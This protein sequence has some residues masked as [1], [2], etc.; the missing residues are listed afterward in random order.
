MSSFE[1]EAAL[2]QLDQNFERALIESAHAD[3]LP[4]AA[5]DA[6]WER[7]AAALAGTSALA[8]TAGPHAISAAEGGRFGARHLAI[9]WLVIG[10]L[11]GAS[12]SAVVLT[13]QRE[14]S[15]KIALP[16]T[17]QARPA[18]LPASRDE[19][20]PAPPAIAPAPQARTAVAGP[21]APLANALAGSHQ[22]RRVRRP[23]TAAA[24]GTDTTTHAA[25]LAAEVSLLD[26]ALS[27]NASRAYDDGLRVIRDYHQ[28]FPSGELSI[29]A[30]VI[31]L[32]ALAGK[33]DDARVAVE[34][35]RFLTR[36]PND[37]H[38]AHVRQLIRDRSR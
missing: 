12:L 26:A 27:A 33:R 25:T 13:T 1:R 32:D 35:E 38:A 28:R 23:P 11:G 7:F 15:P 3:A 37:P 17:A 6:A 2:H 9:K 8:R 21:R 31:A 16:A 22:E 34:A 29:D 18:A 19:H 5:T 30:E 24:A 14:R 10:A 4:S 36:Y 20:R